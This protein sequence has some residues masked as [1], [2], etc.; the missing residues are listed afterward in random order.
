[1][2]I[3]SNLIEVHFSHTGTIK[4]SAPDVKEVLLMVMTQ[5]TRILLSQISAIINV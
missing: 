5:K 3:G 1:M 4:V 2:Y